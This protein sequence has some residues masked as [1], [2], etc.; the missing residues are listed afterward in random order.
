M[1]V[2]VVLGG[3]GHAIERGR[4]EVPL[5]E[6]GHDFFIDPVADGCENPGFD[7]RALGVDGD[8]DDDIS[9]ETGRKFGAH[10][11]R[12]GKHDRVG[13]MDLVA[14]DGA[15]NHGAERGSGARVLSGNFRISG[16]RE[17]VAGGL[18]GLG[19]RPRPRREGRRRKSQLGLGGRSG[20]GVLSAGRDVDDSIRMLA[21]PV[22]KP[23]RVQLNDL[24]GVRNHRGQQS[25]VRGDRPNYR[26]MVAAAH[27]LDFGEHA[28]Y[29]LS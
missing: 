10:H 11:R 29:T 24:W 18:L 17:M 25:Q 22:G 28:R 9:L 3:H 8:F 13:D 20:V 5:P 12:I 15:V 7:H 2:D 6:G 1:E 4:L 23:C 16:N 26:A 21:I 14:G 27:R 19:V